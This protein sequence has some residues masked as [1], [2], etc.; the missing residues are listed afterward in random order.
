MQETCSA[1]ATDFRLHRSCVR[2]AHDIMR[3]RSKAQSFQGLVREHLHEIEH[4]RARGIPET[5]ILSH[6]GHVGTS[7]GTFRVALYR[8]RQRAQSDKSLPQRGQPIAQS[9]I[10]GQIAQ[11]DV[12]SSVPAPS[13]VAL[14]A[15]AE[16]KATEDS[17]PATWPVLRTHR[18]FMALVRA[19]PDK[20]LF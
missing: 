15:C 20:D 10:S 11:R 3:T 19:T 5:M 18:D 1:A 17:K 4:D 7:I 14:L 9:A 16:V 2:S 8:A 13:P 12:T 6:L